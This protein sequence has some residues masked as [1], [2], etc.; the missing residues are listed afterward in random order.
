MIRLDLEATVPP[1]P[2]EP[3][4]YDSIDR[5]H[6]IEV[7]ASRIYEEAAA[8]DPVEPGFIVHDHYDDP[9]SAML[10]SESF[11]SIRMPPRAIAKHFAQLSRIRFKSNECFVKMLFYID[12]LAEANIERNAYA[13]D[14][15]NAFTLNLFVGSSL[16]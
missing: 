7:V 1:P 13:K 6:L 9:V 10:Y 16:S 2:N 14:G 15:R 5:R 4:D 3:F 12:E 8:N 11:R